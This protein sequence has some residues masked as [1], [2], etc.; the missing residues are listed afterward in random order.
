MDGEDWP[1]LLPLVLDHQHWHQCSMPE[2][3]DQRDDVKPS[4]SAG[5]FDAIVRFV[6]LTWL[7][8]AVLVAFAPAPADIAFE[9]SPIARTFSPLGSTILQRDLTSAYFIDLRAR[10][11]WSQ[12]SDRSTSADNAGHQPGLKPAPLQLPEPALHA[13]FLEATR[14]KNRLPVLRLF[15][16]RA[17]PRSV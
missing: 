8:F 2:K 11:E 1:F 9:K 5:H 12:G 14:R 7:V 15:D 13:L 4:R 6:G 10:L 16:A 3:I 17:P